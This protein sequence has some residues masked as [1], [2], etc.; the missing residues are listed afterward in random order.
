MMSPAPFAR[1][2]AWLK[3][4]RRSISL[5]LLVAAAAAIPRLW[6]LNSHS[7][8]PDELVWI[9]HG[10]EL[11]AHLR[12]H[13]FKKA[14]SHFSHPGVLPAALIGYSYVYLGENASPL[15]FDHLPPL[16][17]ARL[18]IAIVGTATC[19][20]LYLLG[21]LAL[22]D[23][24]AFWAA[25]LL[26]LYPHHIA[27][28]RIA[29]VDSTLTF[30]VMLS[31]L[32]YLLYAERRRPSW[33]IAS[34]VFFALAL[35]T[36]TTAMLIPLILIVWK[37]LAR[38]RRRDDGFRFREASDLGWLGLSIALY[39]LL[40]T[41]LW[42][43]P[44][45]I[46]WKDYVRYLPMTAGLIA[47]INTIAALP[48]LQTG[49]IIFGAYVLLAA[50]GRQRGREYLTP[51]SAMLLLTRSVPALLFFCFVFIQI[52]RKP[53]VNELMH[54]SAMS[55]LGDIGHAKYWMGEIVT[56]PPAWFYLFMLL[57]CTPPAML[58]FLVI[59][60]LHPRVPRSGDRG[61][62]LCLAAPAVFIG[63]MSMGH[64]MAFRYIAPVFPFLCL[65]SACGFMGVMKS[66]S[67]ITLPRRTAVS[68]AV[69]LP[70][71]ASL[72]APLVMVAPSYGIYCNFL[73]GGPPGAA[74]II[75]LGFG[76]G[77]KEA[78]AYLKKHAGSGD[79]IF[80]VGV[81]GDFRY[82]WKSDCPPPPL[83]VSINKA[84]PP[85]VDWLVVPLGHRMRNQRVDK[86]LQTHAPEKVYTA[87]KCGVDFLDVYKIADKSKAA[88]PK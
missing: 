7:L 27:A 44:H 6:D 28:S 20:L 49:A 59:G 61:Y 31:L 15:S 41:R 82:H 10:R 51:R 78:V 74:R 58:L 26:S 18:P 13:E 22:G 85:N 66:I 4:N 50:S 52:F 86:F 64:K 63:V 39:F 80:A 47:T 37:A 53:I 84:L 25:L 34:A 24:I 3:N 21:R 32:C 17:A 56:R 23:G 54:I 36:K 40:F 70:L 42:Y 8:E 33:K 76:V 88:T 16:A 1:I 57:I 12:A 9:A 19:I 48:W 73:V 43:E 83:G 62:L 46:F 77:T 5:A 72:V 68:I 79:D 71:T 69:V 60:L 67:A 38:L 87:T 55:Y 30:C 35:L 75:S 11:V 29:H 65:I 81:C 45:D 2:S 14:T